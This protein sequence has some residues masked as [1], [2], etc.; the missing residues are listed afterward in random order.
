MSD[1]ET[2][3]MILAEKC[4]LARYGDGEIRLMEG[5]NITFQDFN[6]V[7]AQKLKEVIMSNNKNVLIAIP[8]GLSSL[9]VN[10]EKEQS[11]WYHHLYKSIDI[12]YK[13]LN[14][15][16]LYSNSQISR[17]YSTTPAFL[18]ES[19]EEDIASIRIKNLKRLWDKRDCVFIEGEYSRLGVGNNCFENAK[20]IRRILC[21][22]V[23]AFSKYDEIIKCVLEYVNK[24]ELLI[25]A[26]GPT[27]T[28]LSYELANNGYQCLDL[29]HIDIEYEWWRTNA[30]G[31]QGVRGKYSN[32]AVWGGNQKSFVEGALSENEIKIYR[33]Q[34]IKLIS[35]DRDCISSREKLR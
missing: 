35:G 21:P 7:L 28:V 23:N 6:P 24:E 8:I 18:G 34:I 14:R 5:D 2:V 25:I 30:V 27:A 22:A 20:S 26:L 4:S 19:N 12:W 10:N 11:F 31:K 16:V 29:G 9:K 3:N 33:N 13:Y 1:E 15:S 17:F 32:E